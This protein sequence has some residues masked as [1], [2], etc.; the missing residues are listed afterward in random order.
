METKY[1]IS[2]ST[3]GKINERTAAIA[4]G[5]NN[6]GKISHLVLL[7]WDTINR[8]C[9]ILTI[10]VKIYMMNNNVLTELLS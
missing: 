10:F 1:I 5:N 4:I 3:L 9:N 8:H 6:H 7:I 2:K